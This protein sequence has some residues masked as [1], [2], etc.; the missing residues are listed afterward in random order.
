MLPL[1]AYTALQQ[2]VAAF[3]QQHGFCTPLPPPP[4]SPPAPPPPPYEALQALLAACHTSLAKRNH[5]HL[6]AQQAQR[7]ARYEAGATLLALAAELHLPPTKVAR[8]LLEGLLEVRRSEVRDLLKDPRAVLRCALRSECAARLAAAAQ[9]RPGA[10]AAAAAAS[11]QQLLARLAAEV[12]HCVASDLKDSPLLDDAREWSGEEHEW[13]LAA[14][15]GAL[16]I[17][18][19]AMLT[20]EELRQGAQRRSTPDILLRWPIVVPCPHGSAAPRLVSWFDSKASFADPLALD[21]SSMGI[22]R[23]VKKYL[24]D[25]GPGMVVFWGGWVD[26]LVGSSSSSLGGGLVVHHRPPAQWRWASEEEKAA[27]DA[28]KAAREEAE[29]SAEV[30][31]GGAQ[32]QQQQQQ[33]PQPQQE[34]MMWEAAPEGRGG[35]GGAPPRQPAAASHHA[36]WQAMLAEEAQR[37]H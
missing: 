35:G 33:Q 2:Q 5:R 14:C 25:F 10:A 15:L 31:A 23:Q 32:Q 16:G 24:A 17:P 6:L 22:G 26:S 7:L 19:A 9:R 11:P 12:A 34:G 3:V 29:L 1:H 18:A 20:E 37:A 27:A 21:D 13:R 28:F 4:P 36:A 30:A 8:D